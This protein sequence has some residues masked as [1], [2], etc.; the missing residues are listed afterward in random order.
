M[1]KHPNA[2]VGGTSATGLGLLIV[3]VAAMFGI[4]IPPEVAVVV[5]AACGAA[6]LMVGRSGVRGVAR[7]LW[8][9]EA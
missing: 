9:G 6:V 5:A 4:V 8:K 1:H 2:V 7:R 3:Y